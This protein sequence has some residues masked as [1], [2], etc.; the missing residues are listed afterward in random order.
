MTK[1]M[2][3]L[4]AE[5]VGYPLSKDE[6]SQI[7]GRLISENFR[8]DVIQAEAPQVDPGDINVSACYDPELDSM[9]RTCIELVLVY[10][11]YDSILIIDDEVFDG[12]TKRLCDAI[13]HEQ[14]H[15]Q[16]HRAR[17]WE[18]T[19]FDDPD[20]AEAYLSHK[21]EID[22]YSYNIANEL[23]DYAD[24][25]QVLTILNSPSTIKLEHSV[26]LFVYM[27]T[28]EY[29]SNHPVIKRLLKKIT[30]LL[31]EVVKQR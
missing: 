12:I 13:S 15:Q 29:N 7:I 8:V 21:D 26:N 17:F 9:N 28:F 18:E 31:P 16:Q 25:N 10:S 1:L 24:I 20:D 5:L 14:I 3:P 19:W 30:K 4:K 22:A 2:E 27:Q 6:I 23:L 11:P